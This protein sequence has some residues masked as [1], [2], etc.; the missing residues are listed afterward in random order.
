MRMLAEV[1][2]GAVN[3]SFGMLSSGNPLT[4]DFVTILNWY[5][6]IYLISSSNFVDTYNE[7]WF[8]AADSAN[9]RYFLASVNG[10]SA[11]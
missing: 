10:L 8:F 1:S 4:I 3:I 5:S 7:L 6:S 9:L 11:A 2:P